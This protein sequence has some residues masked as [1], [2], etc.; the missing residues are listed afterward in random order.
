MRNLLESG[1]AVSGAFIPETD[2]DPPD[3]ALFGALMFGLK[4]TEYNSHLIIVTEQKLYV[5]Y[6]AATMFISDE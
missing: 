2:P 4:F 6:K 5:K 1:E 3:Q